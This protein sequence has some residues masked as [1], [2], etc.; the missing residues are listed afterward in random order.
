MP[1][2]TLPKHTSMRSIT[3]PLAIFIALACNAQ[4]PSYVPTNGLVGWWPFNG[5][6]NDES[7]NGNNGEVNGASLGQD[8]TGAAN[9][10][11]SFDGVNDRIT[12][13]NNL[14]GSATITSYSISLWFRSEQEVAGFFII[15]RE[16]SNWSY[17]YFFQLNT[18]G[19]GS[20][21]FSTHDGGT[22][23]NGL[24]TAQTD[25]NNDE[26]THA[27]AVLDMSVPQMRL[28]INGQ[29]DATGPVPHPTAWNP[30]PTGTTIGNSTGPGG[31][32]YPYAGFLDDIGVW[33]RALTEVEVAAL[34]ESS[35]L[36]LS[37]VSVGFEGLAS[38]YTMSDGPAALVGMPS[39]G[40]FTGAG[41]SG[42]VFHPSLAGV[43]THGIAYTYVDENGCINTASLCT[44]VALG[45]GVDGSNMGMEGGVSVYPNPSRG[46][47]TLELSL[48]GLISMQ[49]FDAAGRIAHTE[50]FHA[51]GERTIRSLDLGHLSKGGYVMRISNNGLSVSQTLVVE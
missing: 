13:A 8:R 29:L 7:G 41:M 3:L 42:S 4:P 1:L 25:L 5:N 39:G 26:W 6:A 12:I 50:V 35:S 43:G 36:C 17:K 30:A 34:F 18:F 48:Q 28:Y 27:V 2:S 9:A 11:Y 16:A 14:I 32:Y 49:V 46:Q 21:R 10:A 22:L 38:S 31:Q 15:D 24:T 47:F 23:A 51:T 19:D 40:L 20:I 44:E 45:V 33:D 37:P